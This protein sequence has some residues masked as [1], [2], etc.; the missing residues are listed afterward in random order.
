M[1]WIYISP[2]LDDA[3]YSC[4]GL[5]WEQTQSGQEVEIWTICA[6]DPPGDNYSEFAETLHQNWNLGDKVISIRR[7][8]DRNACQILGSSPRYF[9]TLDCIYRTSPSGNFYY[10]SEEDLFGGLDTGEA[11]LIKILSEE[12]TNQIPPDAKVASPLGIGNHVDHDLVRKAISRTGMPL[13]Y[14]ADYPYVREAMGQ[15]I[16]EYLSVSPDWEKETFQISENG[17]HKWQQASQAYQSQITTFWKDEG[18]L[19]DEIKSFSTSMGGVRLW[20]TVEND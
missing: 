7:D 18:K 12:L 5:I 9:S 4:G 3:V 20:K 10:Q 13:Y 11:P 6:A 8:E 14:Y 2:H 17:I 15:E 16:L 1:K 19:K